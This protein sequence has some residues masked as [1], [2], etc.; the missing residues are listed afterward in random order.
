MSLLIV[1]IKDRDNNLHTLKYK[2]FD[3]FLTNRWVKLTKNNLSNP[4]CRIHSVFNNR[5]KDDVQD[6]FT[7]LNTITLEIN[8]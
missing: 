3:T 4:Q 2:L 6:I 7:S 1:K 8:N 5:T